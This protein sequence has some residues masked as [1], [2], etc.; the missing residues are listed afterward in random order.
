MSASMNK[1]GYRFVLP[2]LFH[3]SSINL[4]CILFF[5]IIFSQGGFHCLW[6]LSCHISIQMGRFWVF[7]K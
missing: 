7:L 2:L 4:L 3:Y 1:Q 5:L 6:L